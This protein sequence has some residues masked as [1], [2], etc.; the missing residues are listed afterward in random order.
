LDLGPDG[1]A[2]GVLAEA[3]ECQ[4]HELFGFGQHSDA[5]AVICS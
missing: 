4:Q 3:Q 2:V 5:G 1:H